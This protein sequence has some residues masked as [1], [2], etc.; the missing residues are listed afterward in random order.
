MTGEGTI[1]CARCGHSCSAEAWRARP[2]ERT[3][4][5]VDLGG[6]VIAWP[7]DAVVEVRACVGC[8]KAIA[9]RVTRH[10]NRPSFSLPS[11][12]SLRGMGP[13]TQT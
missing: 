1:R 11:E 9:R 12:T 10:L 3:L 2:T 13:E 5:H 7:A 8:G 6:C 4:T